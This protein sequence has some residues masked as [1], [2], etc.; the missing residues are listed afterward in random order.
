MRKKILMSLLILVLFA[1]SSSTTSRE[2]AH[3]E[4]QEKS[5][6]ADSLEYQQV[7]KCEQIIISYKG[8]GNEDTPLHFK[9]FWG[10]ENLSYISYTPY[11]EFLFANGTIEKIE[12]N[13]YKYKAT[14]SELIIRGP[15]DQLVDSEVELSS[16]Y[17][18]VEERGIYLLEN[19][20]LNQ[21]KRMT[22][23]PKELFCEIEL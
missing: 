2:P 10:S 23:Y 16:G 15:E 8:N 21:L 11:A 6:D 13:I 17:I 12:K 22:G 4:D 5:F 20:E 7:Y 3:V 1:C 14:P 18:V 19:Y 9:I